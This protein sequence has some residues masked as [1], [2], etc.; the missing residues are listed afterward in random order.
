MSTM[1]D[2]LRPITVEIPATWTAEQALAVWEILDELRQKIWARYSRQLQDLLADEQRCAGVDDGDAGSWTIDFGLPDRPSP[3][4]RA[5]RPSCCSIKTAILPSRPAR[6]HAVARSGGPGCPQ[7]IAAG[8]AQR[9]GRLR[10]RRHSHRR[11]GR[12]CDPP[13]RCRLPRADR[14]APFRRGFTPPLTSRNVIGQMTQ[15]RV[16]IIA[17][18]ATLTATSVGRMPCSVATWRISRTPLDG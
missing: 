3:D 16:S 6:V 18:V 1:P 4:H 5:Q 15:E 11:D 2:H 14:D 7:G 12:Q 9:P 17:C 10:A 8:D 13:H